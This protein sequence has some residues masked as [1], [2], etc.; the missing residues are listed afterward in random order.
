LRRAKSAAAWSTALTDPPPFCPHRQLLADGSP[1]TA[2]IREDRLG[3]DFVVNVRAAARP[4]GK[5]I[6]VSTSSADI[7][8][9][10]RLEEQ[11]LQAQKMEAVGQLAGGVA[12]DLQ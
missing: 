4:E 7:T 11:I 9:S 12:H 1:H 10:K 8:A 2:E 6:A 3:G 5:L